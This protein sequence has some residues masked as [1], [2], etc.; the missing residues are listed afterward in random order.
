MM[1]L[2]LFE[3]RSPRTIA[4][5]ARILDGEGK[6]VMAL[7]GGTDLL[8]NMKR[9]Q[10]VPRTLMS[11]RQVAGLREINLDD[12]G[13]KLG[14]VPH[15]HR[16]RGGYAIPQ[17]IFRA[18]AGCGAS[19]DAAHSQRGHAGRKHLPGHALQLL[20]SKLRMAESNQFLYEERWGL[21]LGRAQ[22]P[23]MRGSII[24]GHRAGTDRVR[25]ARETCFAFRR[26]RNFAFGSF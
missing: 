9:R 25:R 26:T 20:R 5:A 22:Q 1:R 2:P 3:F 7:A 6:N 21:M 17:R 24:D 11:L 12:S 14:R 19:G 23:E 8:P 4:E 16:Y 18:V 13:M 15:A 10:Q